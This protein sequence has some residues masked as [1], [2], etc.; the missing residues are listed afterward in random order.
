[1]STYVANISYIYFIN[2]I[3]NSDHEYDPPYEPPPDIKEAEKNQHQLPAAKP[4][5]VLRFFIKHNLVAK[6]WLHPRV[7]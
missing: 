7:H 6:S 4:A 1:M 2:M 3:E 5:R